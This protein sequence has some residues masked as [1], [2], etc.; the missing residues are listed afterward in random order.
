LLLDAIYERLLRVHSQITSRKKIIYFDPLT[1]PLSKIFHRENFLYL[2]CLKFFNPLSSLKR[3]VIREQPLI[4]PPNTH[5]K[6]RNSPQHF[7]KHQPSTPNINF[8]SINLCTPKNFRSSIPSR[9]HLWRI[10]FS[11]LIR[12]KQSCKTKVSD[13]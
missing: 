13:S 6:Q 5:R 2:H 11:W 8:A 1:L 12:I 9:C 4:Q 3:N 10:T 7:S